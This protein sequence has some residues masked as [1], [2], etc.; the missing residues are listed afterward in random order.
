M[1]PKVLTFWVQGCPSSSFGSS[2]NSS[3][4]GVEVY[5]SPDPISNSTIG[6]TC[7]IVGAHTKLGQATFS[8]SDFSGWR[9]VSI[10]FFPY[11]GMGDNKVRY[12]TITGYRDGVGCGG[13][14]MYLDNFDLEDYCCGDYM[15]YQ[16]FNNLPPLTQRR[17]YIYAGYNVG[18][19]F[20]PVGE[21]TVQ[22]NQNVT[23]QAPDVEATYAQGFNVI[24]PGVFT[25]QP[26]GCGI[27]YPTS[28][29]DIQLWGVDDYG[30]LNC[31]NDI[32]DG[33]AGFASLGASYYRARIFNSSG[34]L[35]YD[36]SA[37]IH[38]IYTLFWDGSGTF[39]HNLGGEALIYLQLY[40]CSPIHH[41]STYTYYY[42]Y[43]AGCSPDFITRP[44]IDSSNVVDSS[45]PAIAD[46]KVFPI[47]AA[48]TLYIQFNSSSDAPI[49]F[50][51]FNELGEVVKTITAETYPSNGSFTLDLK[52]FSSGIYL[53]KKNDSNATEVRKFIVTN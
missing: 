46:F 40:N 52:S 16:D 50:V 47:P 35:I 28:N 27:I 43:A 9:Q 6:T 20:Q 33:N 10:T 37:F 17:N 2:D 36:K 11:N 39:T 42:E 34:G 31:H 51:I 45:P 22:A 1:G 18:C 15:L 49:G 25:M 26:G 5:G 32:I 38:E 29:Y 13:K 53:I 23:F 21:V 12:I 24:N 4:W 44:K 3:T 8:E 30:T 41:D 48:N 19:T 7:A 14:Y